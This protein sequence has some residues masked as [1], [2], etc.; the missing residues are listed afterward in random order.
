MAGSRDFSGFDVGLNLLVS[1]LA[2]G[3]LGYMIDRWLD[4]APL[5]LL[6]GGFL[7]FASWF[8]HLWRMMKERADQPPDSQKDG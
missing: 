6:V 4:I 2:V 1:V 7:G 8:W 3:G 5:G